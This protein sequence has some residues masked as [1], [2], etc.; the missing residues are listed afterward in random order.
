M[1]EISIR[2]LGPEGEPPHRLAEQPSVQPRHNAFVP[3]PPSAYRR[4]ERWFVRHPLTY[5]L[6]Y[7]LI[8][9]AFLLALA[10]QDGRLDELRTWAYALGLFGFVSWWASSREDGGMDDRTR[11]DVR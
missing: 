9:A 11:I 2:H 8:F 3:E 1:L 7:G 5:G 4:L 6:V 10:A